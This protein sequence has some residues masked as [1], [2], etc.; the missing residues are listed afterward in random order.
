MDGMSFQVDGLRTDLTRMKDE[1][2][3]AIGKKQ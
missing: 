2:L 3:Q 1:I